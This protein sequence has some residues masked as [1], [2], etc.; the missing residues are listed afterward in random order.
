MHSININNKSLYTDLIVEKKINKKN[1]KI[2]KKG[3]CII[4]SLKNNNYNYTTI[5]FNDITDKDNFTCVQK[6]LVEELKKY[7][8]LESNDSILVIGLGNEKSTPDALGPKTID[9]ILVTRYLYLLG[10]VSNNYS[11]VSAFKPN[12]M[13]NTG[14]ESKDIIFNL[15]KSTKANK[16]IIIDA[17]KASHINRLVKTI[18]ITDSGI[19]PGSGINNNRIELNSKSLNTFIIAIGIPTVVDVKTILNN[20][21]KKDIYLDNNLIVTPTDIDYQIE[22]LSLLLSNSINICLHKDYIRQNNNN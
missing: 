3:N 21:L 4:T 14:I 7:L 11:N 22:R 9:N 17:L 2:V 19:A 10:D 1:S 6:I 13:G 8:K 20:I 16:V 15:V 12:V 18:Q 5:S